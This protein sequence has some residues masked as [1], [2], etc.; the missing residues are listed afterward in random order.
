MYRGIEIVDV[1]GEAEG[2]GWFRVIE[3]ALEVIALHDPRRFRRLRSD[4]TRICIVAQG[5]EYYETVLQCYFA[6]GPLLTARTIEESALVLVHEAT[7]ARLAR[8]GVVL[9]SRNRERM[10]RFC[11]SQEME[12]AASLTDAHGLLQ[13]ASSKLESPWWSESELAARLRAQLMG[14]GT[15]QWMIR[16]R[17]AASR[18]LRKSR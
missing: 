5:G 3:D 16:I 8:M 18:L 11:V 14:L 12:F 7:H 10:E 17:E 13:L 15:P 4:L 9:T 2:K 1:A 6:E